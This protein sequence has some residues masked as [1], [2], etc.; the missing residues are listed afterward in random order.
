MDCD[1]CGNEI[2]EL[3]LGKI[4]GTVVKINRDNKNTVYNICT[5]C[6]KK[7]KDL[8]AELAKK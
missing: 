2:E 5:N 1:L 6:Q 8:R 3:F 7:Y 4:K